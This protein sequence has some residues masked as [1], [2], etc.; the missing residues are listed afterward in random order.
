REVARAGWVQTS[1]LSYPLYAT[2]GDGNQLITIDPAA[3]TATVV[4]PFGV[5]QTWA[6]AFAPDGTFWTIIHGFD[7]ALAQL[8]RVDLATGTATHVAGIT[9]VD[10]EVMGL[11]IHPGTGTF[12]AT[13]FTSS[14]ALYTLDPATGAAT[15]VGGGL[16]VPA[17]HGGDF[18]V[19][20]GH[21]V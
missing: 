9:G 12:Y 21:T 16:G 11:M 13:T 7:P 20:D 19:A 4:G 1:P 5:N 3:G 6:G 14:S 15:R 18:G 17:P 10:A 2:G 8:A